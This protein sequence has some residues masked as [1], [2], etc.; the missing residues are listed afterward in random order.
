MLCLVLSISILY[1]SCQA[2][3]NLDRI[4]NPIKQ[5]DT[6][7]SVTK[8]C[9]EMLN[10]VIITNNKIGYYSCVDRDEVKIIEFSKLTLQEIILKRQK[11]VEIS[12]KKL[13]ILL[14]FLPNASFKNL[15]AAI[16]VLQ[17]NKS[18]FAVYG[19]DN[20]DSTF[21]QLKTTLKSSK[22]GKNTEGPKR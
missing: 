3:P 22:I 8:K 21:F 16:S 14:K 15:E 2:P 20:A 11:D 19:L 5:E 10:L 7:F 13:T 9:S 4:Q 17:N 18:N 1:S 12:K 6:T